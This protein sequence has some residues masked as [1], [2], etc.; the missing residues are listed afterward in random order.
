MIIKFI[1][2]YRRHLNITWTIITTVL[3]FWLT[4]YPPSQDAKVFLYQKSKVDIFAVND[5]VSELKVIL[6]GQDLQKEKLNIKIVKIKLINEGR[7]D[8]DPDDYIKSIP[9]GLKVIDGKIFRININ[10]A[11]G[12]LNQ[13]KLVDKMSTD[14]SSAY[15]TPLFIGKNE[16][17]IFD[18]WVIHDKAKEPKI[19]SVGRI[20]N[21]TIKYS[22]NPENDEYSWDDFTEDV[23][24]I[25]CLFVGT[26]ALVLFIQFVS[27][28]IE[29][30]RKRRL[31]RLFGIALD[32]SNKAQRL[33]LDY[34]RNSNIKNFRIY[35]GKFNNIPRLQEL[36]RQFQKYQLEMRNYKRFMIDNTELFN[37]VFDEDE[38]TLF[39]TSHFWFLIE[40]LIEHK[41]ATVN[42]ENELIVSEEFLEQ[43]N[44][45]LKRIY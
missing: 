13:Q 10:K 39:A 34:A 25:I 37:G 8:V 23:V 11:S 35:L 31:K 41:L 22:Y 45:I 29:F 18:V 2:K 21:A 26:F 42:S 44:L 28:V 7:S 17:T 5:P 9:F 16:Y 30:K 14:S 38:E 32:E 33:L 24:F 36:Y 43:V 6:D 19:Q 20:A 27:W 4:F 1:K 40:D 3:A 15:F 12:A